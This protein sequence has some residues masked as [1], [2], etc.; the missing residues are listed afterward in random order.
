MGWVSGASGHALPILLE[1]QTYPSLSSDDDFSFRSAV[2][3]FVRGGEFWEISMPRNP[4]VF[5]I[6]VANVFS[7]IFIK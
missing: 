3:D 4:I 6:S 2:I 1:R 5:R 7:Y